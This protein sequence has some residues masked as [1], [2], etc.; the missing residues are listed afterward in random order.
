MCMD[1]LCTLDAYEMDYGCVK[2]IT[3]LTGLSFNMVLI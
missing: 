2:E 1:F 3:R